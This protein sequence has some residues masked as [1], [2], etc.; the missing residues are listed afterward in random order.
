MSSFSVRKASCRSSTMGFRASSRSTSQGGSCKKVVRPCRSAILWMVRSRRNIIIKPTN[1]TAKTSY[2]LNMALT[3]AGGYSRTQLVPL[4][5]DLR[6]EKRQEVRLLT[7]ERKQMRASALA[8][9]L[10]SP[11]PQGF[12]K[13]HLYGGLT[14]DGELVQLPVILLGLRRRNEISQS[15]GAQ[16]DETEVDAVQERPGRLQRA[17]DGRRRHEEAQHHHGQQQHEVHHGGRP[18]LQAAALQVA[19]GHD[20]QRVHDPLDAGG[21]HQ[22]GEGDSDQGVE[23]GEDLARVRQGR[24]VT[25]TCGRTGRGVGRDQTKK[26]AEGECNHWHRQLSGKSVAS[27]ARC[28]CSDDSVACLRRVAGSNTQ[29][30]G[31]QQANDTHKKLWAEQPLL[32]RQ[33]RC[34]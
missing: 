14:D 27:A 33:I 23:D 20:D 29:V 12:G 9:C 34:R 11:P 5:P 8:P 22:H 25:V 24:G 26:R 7:S 4:R 31:Q 32:L 18:G 6:K 10:W 30:A 28:L 17:E 2:K 13:F 19:D 3:I 16:G 15:D 21:K 1:R